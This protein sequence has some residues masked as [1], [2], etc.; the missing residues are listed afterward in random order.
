[1]SIQ[2]LIGREMPPADMKT[3]KAPWGRMLKMTSV[4]VTLICLGVTVISAVSMPGVHILAY[5]A[6]VW[7]PMLILFG[8]VPFVVR[9][10]AITDDAILIRRLFWDTRLEL[11]GL[12]SAEVVPD[13]M[14]GSIRTCGNGGGFSITGWYWSRRLGSHRAYVTDLNRTVVLG[15]A[16][17]KVVISPADP[18]DFVAELNERLEAAGAGHGGDMRATPS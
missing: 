1:M 9:S 14:R 5:V 16:K 15:F 3:H 4:M 12:K 17:R 13:A 11:A 2:Q 18:A 7:V 6:V 10:Y 8:C